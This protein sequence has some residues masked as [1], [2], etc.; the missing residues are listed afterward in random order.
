MKCE[1]LTTTKKKPCDH[2][3][4]DGL[5][6]MPTI[7]RCSE[8]IKHNEP[9]LSYS[10]VN[11]FMQC[12]WKYYLGYIKG[13]RIKEQFKSD[14]VKIG[15]YVDTIITLNGIRDK[16]LEKEESLWLMKAFAIVRAYG[17]IIKPFPSSI[18]GQKEFYI[19]EDGY[20]TIHGFTDL[21]AP[22][23]FFELKCTTRP[24]YYTNKY[25]IHDQ[26]GTYFLS[27][28]NYETGILLAIRTPQLKQTGTFKDETLDEY[29]ERCYKDM[30]ARP[31]FYFVGYNKDNKTFGVKFYRTEFDLDGLRERYKW[32]G[33]QIQLCAKKDYWYQNKTSCM[34]PFICD[35]LNV[36]DSGGVNE[37][38]YEYRK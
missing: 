34:S 28:P 10:G 36:C 25:W 32:I 2:Y 35:Y 27:N 20:P 23:G 31:S 19:R 29:R 18:Q 26:M 37:D 16:A 11:A 15:S 22:K 30:C 1:L 17:E 21:H 13:I 33:N 12:P 5:C 4:D 8:Y 24:D 3:I 7:F 6:A 9:T 38:T 14:A